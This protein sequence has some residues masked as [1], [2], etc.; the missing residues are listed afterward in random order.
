[1]TKKGPA[2]KYGEPTKTVAVRIPQSWYNDIPEGTR[3]EWIV[4]AIRR[5]RETK[6]NQQQ[7]EGETKCQ[8]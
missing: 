3:T 1:L 8:K 4:D 6:L 5:K 2:H 7:P